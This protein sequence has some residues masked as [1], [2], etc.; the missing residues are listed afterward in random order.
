ML[1]QE[2]TAISGQPPN[3]AKNLSAAGL[4]RIWGNGQISDLPEPDPKS[5]ATLCVTHFPS[6]A[7]IHDT[8]RYLFALGHQYIVRQWATVS[9]VTNTTG[10]YLNT[11]SNTTV[12]ISI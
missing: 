4:G 1:Y 8:Y 11:S 6:I 7:Y 2:L 9:V 3:A 10:K 5:G 12:K